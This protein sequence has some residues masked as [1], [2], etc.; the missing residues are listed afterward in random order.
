MAQFSIDEADVPGFFILRK[1]NDTVFH[2]MRL[3][4]TV[5]V[6]VDDLINFEQ[7]FVT[8]GIVHYHS[9]KVRF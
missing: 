1:E 7:E 3:N 6:T 2:R 8:N 4:K 5:N 9:K